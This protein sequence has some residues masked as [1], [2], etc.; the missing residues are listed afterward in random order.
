[1]NALNP[2]EL[3]YEELTALHTTVR[4]RL[5]AINIQ[6]EPHFKTPLSDLPNEVVTLLVER[7]LVHKARIIL[8]EALLSFSETVKLPTLW[9]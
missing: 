4:K 2:K 3:N 8:A 7:N 1:M 9:Q 5:K 6:L